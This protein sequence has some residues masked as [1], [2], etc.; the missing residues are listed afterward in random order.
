MTTDATHAARAAGLSPA[1]LRQQ[2]EAGHAPRVLDVRTPGEFRTVH[3]PGSYNVPL[4]TLR[5]HRGELLAHLDEDVVLV[6][7][8]GARA[9][10]AEQALAEAGLP[11]LR[12]LDGGMTAWEAAGA[13]VNRGEARWDLERQVRLVAGSI[14]LVSGVTGIFVPG[15]HLVGT[16]IGAG[17]TFAALSNTCAMGMLLSKLPYNRGPRT[18]IRAVVAALRDRP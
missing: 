13:P 4:D 8:S 9:A 16:A 14:V 17:L 15:A 2:M 10:Q 18:D 7:R 6:C 11:N 1:A 12:V 5:E 3:I